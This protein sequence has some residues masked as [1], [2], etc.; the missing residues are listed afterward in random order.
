MTGA[1]IANE[2]ALLAIRMV[3]VPQSKCVLKL[4]VTFNTI[5]TLLSEARWASL[6]AGVSAFHQH[7]LSMH[8]GTGSTFGSLNSLSDQAYCREVKVLDQPDSERFELECWTGLRL[9]LSRRSS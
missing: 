8:S 9:R 4:L 5:S 7:P 6:I 2:I 3:D 1:S